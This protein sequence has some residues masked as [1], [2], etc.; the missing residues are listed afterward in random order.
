MSTTIHNHLRD[1]IASFLLLLLCSVCFFAGCTR[2]NGVTFNGTITGADGRYLT[3][4][5]TCAGETVLTDSVQIR[6]GHFRLTLP[7]GDDGPAFYRI[8]ICN[9]NAFTTLASKGETV[10]IE[11]DAE[12]L[13]RSYRATGSPDA[14][15]MGQL[16]HQLALF[17]DSTDYLM[18]LYN[19]QTDDDS[20]R[21]AIEWA[22]LQ[23][24]AN[25]TAFLRNFIAQN[26]ESLSCLAAF[27]QRYNQCIFLPEKENVELLQELYGQWKQLYPENKEVQWVGE[28]LEKIKGK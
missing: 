13:V 22:Y 26:S 1:K 27:Y 20:L 23:I 8:S 9:N 24:K 21:E 18:V 11:A 19:Q 10:T 15:R 6:D 2:H 4:T 12:S 3:V 7:V 14:E 5:R 25:H 28:R 17:A 16:D